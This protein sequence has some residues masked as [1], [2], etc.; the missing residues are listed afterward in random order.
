[1]RAFESS[2]RDLSPPSWVRD[3]IFY[4]IVPDRFRTAGRRWT[5]EDRSQQS[6]HVPCGGDLW[7][8]RD[9]VPYL[10]E[11]G[12]T[13]LYLT[14]VFT[15]GTY[16]RYDT[17]DYM[18]TDP[19]LGGDDALRGL[20]DA[21]KGRDMRI[22]LDGVFNHCGDRHP[23]FCEAMEKGEASRY[24]DW[25]RWLDPGHGAYA[26]WAGITS[27]PEWNLANP[28]VTDYLLSVVRHWIAEYGIDGW[29]LDAVDYLPIDFVRQIHDAA[30]ET[31]PQTY[32]MGE[33]MGLARPWYLHGA[34]DGS[35]H[36]RLFEHCAAFFAE[37]WYDAPRFRDEILKL[38]NSLPPEANE[39]SYTFLSSHDTPR[40]LTRCRGNARRY[41]LAAAFLFTYSGAPAIYYGDEIGLRGGEDPDNRRCFP[42]D[43][44]EWNHWIGQSLRE[45]VG[46][47][48]R[49]PALCRGSFVIEEAHGWALAYRRELG[50]DVLLVALNAAQHDEARIRLSGSRWIDL[51]RGVEERDSLRIPP[52]SY[53]I[54]KRSA[55]SS[56]SPS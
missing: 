33:V 22:V 21:L 39:S 53:R 20:I 2:Q 10:A 43:E 44:S 36:Y 55:A 23:F 29:R 17:I 8:I 56:T 46:L 1:M 34:L 30:K 54:L 51:L 12:A 28:Q 47:R 19:R 37:G 16:H 13:A 49:E 52:L 3:A 5:E 32:V 50:G 25:F 6:R 41:L 48:R 24:R 18:E 40:F 15:A 14:P 45:L 4:E 11:L 35:M 7:G 26:A 42:W 31:N 9:A 27:L 38:Y